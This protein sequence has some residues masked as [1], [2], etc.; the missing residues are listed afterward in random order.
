MDTFTRSNNMSSVVFRIVASLC[1]LLVGVAYLRAFASLEYSFTGLRLLQIVY[2]LMPL[3]ILVYVWLVKRPLPPKKIPE[4]SVSDETEACD[5][6]TRPFVQKL[7]YV[8]C[9]VVIALLPVVFYQTT[10]ARMTDRYQ[11]FWE[12]DFPQK[13]CPVLTP[14]ASRG[15]FEY[16]PRQKIILPLDTDRYD[17]QTVTSQ[18]CLDAIN[19]SCI[20]FAVFNALLMVSFFGLIVLQLI[21]ARQYAVERPK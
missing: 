15:F 2:F 3:P 7:F 4:S 8:C 1:G 20:S 14:P 11:C 21:L 12:G 9:L 16:A 6:T 19:P 10:L 17:C 18:E 5:V 13:L